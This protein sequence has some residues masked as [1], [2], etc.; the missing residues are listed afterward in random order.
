MLMYL[1]TCNPSVR[2]GNLGIGHVLRGRTLCIMWPQPPGLPFCILCCSPVEHAVVTSEVL[3]SLSF[4]SRNTVSLQGSFDSLHYT[5]ICS[6]DK[7]ISLTALLLCREA[8]R[9]SLCY[10]L[11]YVNY[12]VDRS[13]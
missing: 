5:P 12:A 8:L 10:Q 9:M 7:G 2:A 6:I 4:P 11:E 3:P 1:D 13:A